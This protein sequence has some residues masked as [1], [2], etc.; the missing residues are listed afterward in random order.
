MGDIGRAYV[1]PV[2]FTRPDGTT[3]TWIVD[4]AGAERLLEEIRRASGPPR[5]GRPWE[6]R[7]VRLRN[8]LKARNSLRAA[9]EPVTQA[10]LLAQMDYAGNTRRVRE[11][12]ADLKLTW[13]E[14]LALP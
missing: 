3:L 2:Q 1:W 13:T 7:E 5:R 12:L 8:M 4:T 6:S 11:W 14:F 9:E 10:T